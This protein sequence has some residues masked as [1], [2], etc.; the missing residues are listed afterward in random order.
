MDRRPLK[1]RGT[2]WAKG[3]AKFLANTGITPNQISILSIFMALASMT[4]FYLAQEKQIFLLLAALFIQL[5][6]LC[7][8]FDG[9]VA[10]EHN[11]KTN[12][13]DIFNDAPD[14]VADVLIILGLSLSVRD[15]PYAIHL[16]WAAS[17]LAVMTAYIRV[18]GKSLG[19]ESYFIGPMAKQHRMFLVTM[20]AITDLILA[21]MNVDFSVSY[22]TLFIIVL[23]STVTCFRRLFKII[24]D[25]EAG[26]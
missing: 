9:M 8:L 4:C 13:G 21:S 7:N 23:G 17:L 5:R 15:L 19:T 10:V 18:L 1:S 2:V 24:K 12:T 25:K 14:R 22:I 6:L 11:K 20:S 3:T 26:L 16:G